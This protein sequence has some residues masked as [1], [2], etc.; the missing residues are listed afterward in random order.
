MHALSNL[1]VLKCFANVFKLKEEEWRLQINRQSIPATRTS[2]WQPQSVRWLGRISLLSW[3]ILCYKEFEIILNENESLQRKIQSQEEEFRLQSGTL[4]QE[5][6]QVWS[7][8]RNKRL[9]NYVIFILLRRKKERNN[10]KNEL[11][12]HVNLANEIWIQTNKNISRD[13]FHSSIY[14]F[15][16]P[17]L[18]YAA[19]MYIH[20]NYVC[21][22]V[23]FM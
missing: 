15:P 20:N 6:G 18:K 4:M 23:L 14:N 16:T 1:F 10:L 3:I 9:I 17:S 21:C 11:Y 12:L 5:L 2:Q 13:S 7:T 22:C 19:T 8:D